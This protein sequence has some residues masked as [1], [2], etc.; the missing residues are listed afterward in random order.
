MLYHSIWV[1]CVKVPVWRVANKWQPTGKPKSMFEAPIPSVWML[2]NMALNQRHRLQVPSL[3][4]DLALPFFV[5]L[6]QY[7]G[8]GT[9]PILVRF[10]FRVPLN[11]HARTEPTVR[12]PRARFPKP[13]L[14]PLDSPPG[15]VCPWFRPAF[16]VVAVQRESPGF[17]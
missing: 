6:F 17:I 16:K 2:C 9:P 10:P 14:E 15:V 11:Q 4:P 13:K 5:A 12:R 3:T 1:I 8:T 7:R